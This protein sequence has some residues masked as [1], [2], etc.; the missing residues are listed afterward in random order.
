MSASV[1]LT[2]SGA[3]PEGLPGIDAVVE[4][5]GL[6]LNNT[7]TTSADFYRITEIG[8]LDDTEIRD[9]RESKPQQHGEN[10]FDSYYG[11]KTLTLTGYFEAGNLGKLRLMHQDL[12]KAF[13]D[14]TEKPLYLRQTYFPSTGAH[15]DMEIDCK[16]S[17]PIQVRE[18]QSTSKFKREFLIT[19]KA[20]DCRF[21]SV[22]DNTN[23]VT[24]TLTFSSRGRVFQKTYNKQY[25]YALDINSMPIFGSYELLVADAGLIVSATDVI[26]GKPGVYWRMQET[27]G[28]VVTDTS[29]NSRNGTYQASP[30]L[31]QAG[32]WP[33]IYGVVLNGSTQYIS[34][35]YNPFTNATSR[36]FMGW[37]KRT[38]NS[39]ADTLFGSSSSS[40]GPHLRCTSGADTAQFSA[41][42]AQGY[43]TFSSAVIPVNSWFHWALVFVEGSDL[44]EFFI[45][46]VSQGTI[47]ETDAYNA[48]PGNIQ[49]G[50]AGSSTD[51]FLGSIS[52]FTVY[53]RRLSTQE[54][55]QHYN[56][57]IQVPT[58]TTIEHDGSFESEPIIRLYGGLTNPVVTNQTTNETIT[59]TG[60]I[61][62]GEYIEIDISNRT[63]KDQGG[64]NRFGMLD[65]SSD[66]PKIPVGTSNWQI[67]ASAI[68]DS[69]YMRIIWQAAHL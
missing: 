62:S 15:G 46:G 58:I 23:D 9:S 1:R 50:I 53:E 28:S 20:G 18:A 41:N 2:Y 38:N 32:P 27:S 17:A 48:S 13:A 7:Y 49:V 42:I 36:T 60:T 47:T 43:H 67:T 3:D 52:Q 40:V 31:A 54:I 63:I 24:A 21:Y 26:S 25:A 64:T 30:T 44:A 34:S 57:G 29:G 22:D 6:L 51:P 12:K 35:S 56:T 68:S 69:P 37:A 16:K 4:Y 19:L 55:L 5:N 61:I 39:T 8:G 11:G 10:V 59:L 45:N 33:S 66:W 65:A 14:L